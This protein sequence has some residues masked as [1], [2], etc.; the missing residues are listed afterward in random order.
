MQNS[1]VMVFTMSATVTIKGGF[2]ISNNTKGG[3]TGTLFAT[4]LFGSAQALVSG[5]SLK[6]TYTCSAT[7]S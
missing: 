1:A 5:Q 3:T 7:G 2:L 6:V 4:G